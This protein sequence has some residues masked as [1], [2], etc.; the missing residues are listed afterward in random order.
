MLRWRVVCGPDGV[1]GVGP[2][3]AFG[4]VLCDTYDGGEGMGGVLGIHGGPLDTEPLVPEVGGGGPSGTDHVPRTH[5]LYPVAIVA[6]DIEGPAAGVLC[7]HVERM[8]RWQGDD[9]D[10]PGVSAELLICQMCHG[11]VA[12]ATERPSGEVH[13]APFW[14]GRS[15]SANTAR[16]TSRMSSER[17][18]PCSAASRVRA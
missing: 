10:T 5:L 15:L 16:S 9:V 18:R 8:I 13:A 7:G 6:E 3:Q 12:Q 11:R 17:E 2:L 14:G 1:G 4:V